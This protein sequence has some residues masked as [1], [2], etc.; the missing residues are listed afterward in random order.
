MILNCDNILDFL[1]EKDKSVYYL[2]LNLEK[3]Y[4]FLSDNTCLRDG[5]SNYNLITKHQK[6][7][8]CNLFDALFK[9][10]T[11]GEYIKILKGKYKNS[12]L[13]YKKSKSDKFIL[14][15]L[16]NKKDFLNNYNLKISNY[17]ALEKHFVDTEF[18]STNNK[19]LNLAIINNLIKNI[20]N[21][22]KFIK[23]NNFLNFYIC[24]NKL[25]SFSFKYDIESLGELLNLENY[26]NKT[27]SKKI[28]YLI[29][30]Y[31][32]FFS[33]YYYSHNNPS[34]KS[35]KFDLETF[36][37]NVNSKIIHIPFRIYIEPS[38]YS[39]ITIFN[40]DKAKRYFYN[41][42][43]QYNIYTLPFENIDI[44]INGSKNYN[45]KKLNIEYSL[46]YL[47]KRLI[48]YKIGNRYKDFLN[49]KLY[50]GIP[51][52]SKSFDIVI[53]FVSL[54]L[55]KKYYE[56]FVLNYGLV[57]VWKGLWKNDDYPFL[58]KDLEILRNK[59]INEFNNI[60]NIIKKYYIRFDALEYLYN[61]LSTNW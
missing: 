59:N 61:S 24:N 46:G 40:K 29:V 20:I 35:L 2:L 39:S 19:N 6:C 47:E 38:E 51:L 58:I 31:F 44:D 26:N 54:L 33:N 3:E 14:N 34:I 49:I 9:E 17:Y 5:L 43:I 48:F 18:F 30:L 55:E 13:V 28:L 27:N 60:Y 23:S 52:V 1:Q 22:K 11:L 50:S 4:I 21:I 57:K 42:S 37:I 32:K 36:T 8:E 7:Q 10:D 25:L 41:N 16:K 53:F 12:K 15:Y 45:D 56:K